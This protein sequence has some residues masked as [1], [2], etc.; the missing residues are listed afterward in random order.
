MKIIEGF[1]YL[2]SNI[3][4]FLYILISI[5]LEGKCIVLKNVYMSLCISYLR[6]YVILGF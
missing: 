5:I 3:L 2:D 6:I 1:D 4:D